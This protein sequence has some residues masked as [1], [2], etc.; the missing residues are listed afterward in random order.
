MLSGLVTAIRTL[1]LLPVPG[2]EAK[3]ISS[4]LFWFPIV[5]CWLGMMLYGLSF[6][7]DK[8]FPD[9][10]PE[11]VAIFIVIG[12]IIFTRGI[13]LD[14]LVDWGDTLGCMGGRK[15]L[16]EVMKDSR[17][18]AFGGMML[19]GVIMLKWVALTRLLTLNNTGRWLVVAYVVSRT[20]P[21]ELAACFPYARS[22]G[23]I[24]APFVNNANIFHRWGAWIVSLIL[25]FIFA[26]WV[27]VVTLVGG[28][29]FTHAWGSW[30]YRRL[31]GITGDLLGA[32]V[33]LTETTILFWGAWLGK[34]LASYIGSGK[35]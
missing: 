29:V 33:E 22:E 13:H 7:L 4:S 5:G 23:G 3:E 17:I 1:T 2:K 27:G 25:V 35:I 28:W 8:I 21:V 34:S 15:K 18:G 19:I 20:T 31:G 9:F 14:G 32:S 24:G 26:G 16:L 12:S 30:N 6:L 10:W 11:G